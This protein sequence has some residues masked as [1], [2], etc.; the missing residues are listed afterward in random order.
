[1]F[2]V[3]T[4]NSKSKK[5]KAEDAMMEQYRADKEEEEKSR[6]R[7]YKA[8]ADMEETFS[9]LGKPKPKLLGA[10]KSDARKDFSFEN[11]SEDE[12]MEDEYEANMDETAA[13]LSEIKQLAIGTNREITNQNELLSEMSKK[14]SAL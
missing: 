14:V 9:S 1:M 5:Q 2:S 7:L 3:W 8:N 11:D 10:N 6:H 13:A 4:P 12:A